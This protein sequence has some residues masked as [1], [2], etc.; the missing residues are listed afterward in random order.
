[1]KK[2]KPIIVSVVGARPQF[3]KLAALLRRLD[4]AFDSR[5]VHTGQHYDA[6]M[7]D[8]FFAE[9]RLRRPDENLAVGKASVNL[10]LARMVERLDDYFRRLRPDAALVFGD[11][12]STMAGALAASTHGIPVGHIEA[13][14]RSFDKHMAEERNRVV[15]DHLSTWLFC[16]TREAVNNL[17]AEGIGR[18]ICPVGDVMAETFRI[19]RRKPDDLRELPR[20]ALPREGGYYFVTIHRA[21]AVDNPDHLSRLVDMLTDLDRPIVFPVH[22]RTR[23]RFKRFRLWNRLEKLTGISL[24][25]PVGHRSSLWLIGHSAAVITDSGGVQK[26]AYWAGVRCF[27]LRSVT[28]WGMLVESGWNHLVGFSPAKLK[29]AIR[30]DAK[31]RKIRDTIFTQDNASE[32]IVR[33]LKDTIL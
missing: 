30:S 4:R 1:M 24:L 5:V 11:T 12:T 9:Y 2:R 6:E 33:Q 7:S 17:K 22:P 14:L 15:A 18:G 29:R 28:E 25:P 10:Q 31:P 20:T 23:D 8:D 32:L 3:I 27:T 16:P 21:E 26:E 13:G 19:P